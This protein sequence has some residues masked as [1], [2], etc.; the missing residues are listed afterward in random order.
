MHFCGWGLLQDPSLQPLVHWS[1]PCPGS[2]APHHA[3]CAFRGSHPIPSDGRTATRVL[4]A[5]ALLEH[6][7]CLG[8]AGGGGQGRSWRG[9]SRMQGRRRGGT[10]GSSRAPR[11]EIHI[12]PSGGVCAPVKHRQTLP[13]IPSSVGSGAQLPLGKGPPSL[14]MGDAVSQWCLL[15][16]SPS[17][18]AQREL[19]AGLGS[20]E[21]ARAAD[22]PSIVP[23]ILLVAAALEQQLPI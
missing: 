2:P 4:G 10:A 7:H 6:W 20:A 22:G 5:V 1:A 17:Q 3:G 8:R 18:R 13:A 11:A 23:A 19:C 21:P 9:E 14:G 16:P 12:D 15:S